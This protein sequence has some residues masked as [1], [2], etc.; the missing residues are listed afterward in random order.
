[1]MDRGTGLAPYSVSSRIFVDPLYLPALKNMLDEPPMKDQVRN[2]VAAPLRG[3][4]KLLSTRRR[5][6]ALE[7]L[8]ADVSYLRAHKFYK[9]ELEEWIKSQLDIKLVVSLAEELCQIAYGLCFAEVA[10]R[11]T[12]LVE[13]VIVIQSIAYG[14]LSEIDQFIQLGLDLP[15]GVVPGGIDAEYFRAWVIEDGLIGA[16]PDYFN[17]NGQRWG[18]V[19][20]QFKQDAMTPDD[21]APLS[22][23]LSVYSLVSSAI[24]IDHA[25]G[26]ERLCVIR[27][28]ADS[29][30]SDWYYFV[31]QPRD[32]LLDYLGQVTSEGEVDI[33]AEDLGV[34]PIDLRQQLVEHGL[35]LMKVLCFEEAV[36]PKLNG[37]D[38]AMPTTHDTPTSPWLL[39]AQEFVNDDEEGMSVKL[40]MHLETDQAETRDLPVIS[41]EF[42]DLLVKMAR[43]DKGRVIYFE[44]YL[45]KLICHLRQLKPKFA[46][47]SLRDLTGDMDR[48][49]MPGMTSEDR[50]NFFRPI[51]CGA[52]L[53]NDLLEIS[54]IAGMT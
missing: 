35:H 37:R 48:L 47:L 41:Q 28:D 20:F 1:M 17:E 8:E 9:V 44:R 34:V 27:N 15:V 10:T 30:S 43:S 31:Q 2:Y 33:V 14:C 50:V 24:R 32:A 23:A 6:R 18:L 29:D 51:S 16:P 36:L 40:E 22:I 7:Y 39:T 19:G 3:I 52:A 45:E 11:T 5:S 53:Y 12:N 26:L 21:F 4:A 49:N 42:L 46:I 38:M 13:K 25:I 54:N